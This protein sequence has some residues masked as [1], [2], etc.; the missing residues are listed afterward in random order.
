MEEIRPK[1]EKIWKK[2]DRR[3]RK[4]GRNSTEGEIYSTEGEFF[5]PPKGKSFFPEGEI[6]FP[7]R[8]NLFSPKGKSFFPEGEIFFPR[9][10]DLFDRRE[11]YF[12]HS[13]SLSKER[14]VTP[15]L[16][17]IQILGIIFGHFYI[18]KSRISRQK[19]FL[20]EKKIR[21]FSPPTVGSIAKQ[22]SHVFL[23]RIST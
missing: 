10:G 12:P 3:E 1:G 17:F 15:S 7:R 18:S 6:F 22:T 23:R 13:T 16:F 19:T 5:F 21:S 14:G 8:G 11:I 2:F 4:Y 9:R 20:E